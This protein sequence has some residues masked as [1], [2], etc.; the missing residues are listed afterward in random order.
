MK[1]KSPYHPSYWTTAQWTI[2]T[3]V[4]LLLLLLTVGLKGQTLPPNNIANAK[5]APQYF[6]AFIDKIGNDY[7]GSKL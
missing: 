7:D 5:G 2:F 6:E 4:L 3:I 1:A